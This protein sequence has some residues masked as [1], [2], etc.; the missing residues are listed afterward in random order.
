MIWIDR[1]IWKI[2]LIGLLRGIIKL[3]VANAHLKAQLNRIVFKY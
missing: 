2:T 1:N 3:L